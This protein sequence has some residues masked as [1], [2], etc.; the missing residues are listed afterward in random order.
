VKATL[1]VPNLLTHNTILQGHA[2]DLL[3][4]ILDLLGITKKVAPLLRNDALCVVLQLEQALGMSCHICLAI[5]VVN[6]KDVARL[7]HASLPLWVRAV[8]DRIQ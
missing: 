3:G 6:L 8:L 5:V 1:Q 4:E 7:I 2:T